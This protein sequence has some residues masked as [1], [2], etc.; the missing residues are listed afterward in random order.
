M[1]TALL[2]MLAAA[3]LQGFIAFGQDKSTES[4][5]VRVAEAIRRVG[6]GR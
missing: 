2:T 4:N 3:G 6:A 5:Q 1:K